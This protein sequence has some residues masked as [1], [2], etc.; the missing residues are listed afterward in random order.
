MKRILS[1]V[2]G[3]FTII[4]LI[5][6]CGNSSESRLDAGDLV[7]NPKSASGIDKTVAMPV[8]SFEK[9]EHDFGNLMLGEN[10]TYSFKFE[11]KGN[12]DLIISSVEA[13][14]GCT[15]AKY[16]KEPIKPG[17]ADF[18]SVSF[19]SNSRKGMQNKLVSIMSNT[20]PSKTNL[21]IKANVMI[22]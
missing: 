9:T 1:T 21:R 6:A 15:V 18:I 3:V 11:N 16:N 13:S 2:V 17:K 22:P 19:D 10:V 4:A 5:T 8:I 14:C 20:Q 12:A 7:K